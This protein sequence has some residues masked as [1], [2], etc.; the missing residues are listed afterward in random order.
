M[1]IILTCLLLE[2][3]V[4]ASP[5]VRTSVPNVTIDSSGRPTSVAGAL[6]G[7]IKVSSAA[8][9]Q[10]LLNQVKV[11]KKLIDVCTVLPC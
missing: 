8:Q 11:L 10:A 4:T 6:A 7:A 5:G 3:V 2:Q 1:V 9:Q